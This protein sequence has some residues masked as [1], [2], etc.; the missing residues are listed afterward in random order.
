MSIL[1]WVVLGIVA[2]YVAGYIVKG[3]ENL[4]F[5]GHTLLGVAGALVGGF[6]TVLIFGF[7][8]MHGPLIQIPSFI[9]AIVGSVALVLL[10]GFVSGKPRTGRGL[11]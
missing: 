10:A 4:G 11:V 3:D 9:A 7:D 6:T 2:G 1:A 5:V 8:P